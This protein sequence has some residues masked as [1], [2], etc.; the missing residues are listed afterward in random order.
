MAKGSVAIRMT[1]DY[2][3]HALFQEDNEA[4]KGFVCALLKLDAGQVKSAVV[5]NP[6]ELG[7]SVGDKEF[8]LDIKVLLDDRAIINLELQV[9]NQHNW[10]ERSLSYLCRAFDN[11]NPGEGC[12]RVKPVVHIG[13]LDFTLFPKFPEFYATH[14]LMNVKNHMIYS[15]K[16]QLSLVDLTHIDLATEEDMQHRID[17]WAAFFKAATWEEI[18]MI[19]QRDENIAK[20]ANTVWKLSQEDKIRLQCEAREDYYRNQRDMEIYMEKQ[21]GIIAERESLIACQE[22]TIA[23]NEETIA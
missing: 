23:R 7:T 3:F 13:L 22:G 16:L 9:I 19:A 21:A 17:C 10:P 18:E 4:L 11:L 12:Q 2:L 15:D 5:I 20:A 1:N 6:I 14:R 8:I